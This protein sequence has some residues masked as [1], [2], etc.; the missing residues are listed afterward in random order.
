MYKKTSEVSETTFLRFFIFSAPVIRGPGYYLQKNKQQTRK[1]EHH[2][3][4][5]HK[6]LLI[7]R[8]H[9]LFNRRRSDRF[10]SIQIRN[11]LLRRCSS[12]HR[13]RIDRSQRTGSCRSVL[14]SILKCIVRTRQS[15]FRRLPRNDDPAS[16]HGSRGSGINVIP[17]I[18]IR[19]T[20]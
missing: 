15:T 18:N 11:Q 19:P 1:E 5:Y 20:F 7:I 10:H 9:H 17:A 8:T 4:G 14:R 16:Q 6:S 12:R 3:K 2:D 13:Q